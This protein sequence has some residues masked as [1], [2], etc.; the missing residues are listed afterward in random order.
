VAY[1]DMDVIVTQPGA[2]C[3]ENNLNLS[4]GL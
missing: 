3:I 1:M 2:F 4:T